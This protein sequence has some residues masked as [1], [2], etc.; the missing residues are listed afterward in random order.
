LNLTYYLSTFWLALMPAQPSPAHEVITVTT[1]Q[2]KS[3]WYLTRPAFCWLCCS[4]PVIRYQLRCRRNRSDQNVWL[5]KR[6][7]TSTYTYF[8]VQQLKILKI[9]DGS[10][11][12]DFPQ[13]CYYRRIRH[14]NYYRT[15]LKS[16]VILIFRLENYSVYD[17]TTAIN[18]IITSL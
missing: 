8:N 17:H 11:H 14:N 15:S 12:C 2:Y 6:V 7:G 16:Y 1:F 9:F 5:T 3:V 10:V 4:N 18:V 13:T